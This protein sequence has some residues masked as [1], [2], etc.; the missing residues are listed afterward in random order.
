[1]TDAPLPSI[2]QLRWMCRR[3]MKELDVLAT[4]YLA[5]DYPTAPAEQQAAFVSL[6]QQV[7]DP[8]IWAWAM[9][10]EPAPEPYADIIERLVRRR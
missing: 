5:Q 6:L 8:D 1:M 10:Y 4:R 3:G 7:E 2:S 9:G